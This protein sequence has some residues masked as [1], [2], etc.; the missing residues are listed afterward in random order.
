[1]V[2]PMKN[3]KHHMLNGAPPGT[4]GLATPSGWMNGE[5]FPS[6]VPQLPWTALLNPQKPLCPKTC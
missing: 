2:F 1:M 3:F 5:L 6:K 4:L